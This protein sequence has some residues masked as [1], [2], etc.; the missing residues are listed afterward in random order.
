MHYAVKA[1]GN[2]TIL[3]E[4]AKKGFGV[5]LVSGGEIS[6]A[7]AAGFAANG[8][9]YSGVGKTDPEINLGLDNDIYSF[10]VESVPEL[11]VINELAGKKGKVAN[12][13]IR[14]NPDIDAHTHRYITTGTAE[15]KFGINIEMLSTAVNKALSLPNIHLR[16]LHFHVGSQIT[17]M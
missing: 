1:N 15:D 5:D 17:D 7:L 13:S 6:A 14:V 9:V 3:E 4:I 2:K 16:G 12:I 11:E 8:M 10:N